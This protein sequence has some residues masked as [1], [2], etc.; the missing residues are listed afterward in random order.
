MRYG[1][2]IILVDQITKFC[3]LNWVHESVILT[4]FL[5]LQLCFNRGITWGL[6]YSSGDS[7]RYTLIIFTLVALC[8]VGWWIYTLARTHKNYVPQMCILAAG[9]SNVIDRFVHGGVVDFI[10][11][12]WRTF[13]WPA[14]NIADMVIVVAVG[15]LVIQELRAS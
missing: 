8:A 3:A 13:S 6:G 7:V 2:I 10:V 1:I 4:P 14:F 9:L 11:L 5:S 12:S 15:C